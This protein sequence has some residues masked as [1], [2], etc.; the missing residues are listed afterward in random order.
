MNHRPKLIIRSLLFGAMILLAS[1]AAQGQ[2]LL[3][4]WDF[5]NDSQTYNSGTATLGKFYTTTGNGNGEI[6]NTTSKQLSSNTAN[7]AIYT[8]SYI[9][10]SNWTGT[11]N[12]NFVTGSTN[13][14][15][16]YSDSTVNRAS[17]DSSTGG[18]LM[19]YSASGGENGSYITFSLDSAGYKSLNLTYALRLSVANS[20]LWSYSTDGTNWTSL[21]Y[22]PTPGTTFTSET[23]VLPTALN[24]LSS[25]YLRATLS[26]SSTSESIALDNIQLTGIAVPEPSTVALV[27]AFCVIGLGLRSRFNFCGMRS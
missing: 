23:L 22:A 9:S 3:S 17:S 21:G 18:S 20:V 1:R 4:Y 16:V 6:Y 25:F 2:V 12:G 8:S 5:N 10:F 24:N 13:G 19:L 15:G 27:L 7:G 26:N 11:A 14:W